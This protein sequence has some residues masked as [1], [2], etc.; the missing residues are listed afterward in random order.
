MELDE[1]LC[2]IEKDL[3]NLQYQS[4]CKISNNL[5]LG[6]YRLSNHWE[7]AKYTFLN[8]DE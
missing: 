3:Y 8:K 6:K 2:E 4:E 1:M 5:A 7:V